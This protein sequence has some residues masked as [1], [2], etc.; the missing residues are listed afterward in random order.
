MPTRIDDSQINS[1][2]LEKLIDNVSHI[3]APIDNQSQ[4]PISAQDGERIYVKDLQSDF[5]YDANSQDWIELGISQQLKEKV[6]I[7]V[8]QKPLL[9]AQKVE[10]MFPYNGAV[11]EI[12]S[13]LAVSGLSNTRIQVQKCSSFNY[14]NSPVWNDISEEL[15]LLANK[16]SSNQQ[17]GT[18][19]NVSLND[20]FRIDIKELGQDVEGLTLNIKIQLS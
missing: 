8:I 11:S 6:I 20:Y 14:E 1:Q 15:V 9:G 12:S 3:K 19:V 18:P 7:F 13:T 10:I 5:V 2:K 17:L 4:L 16:K